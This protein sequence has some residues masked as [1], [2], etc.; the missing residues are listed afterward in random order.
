MS[1]TPQASFLW[2]ILQKHTGLKDEYS[3]FLSNG[4]RDFESELVLGGMKEYL[5]NP[6]TLNTYKAADEQF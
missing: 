1:L 3:F 5:Y 6:N 2:N 4:I